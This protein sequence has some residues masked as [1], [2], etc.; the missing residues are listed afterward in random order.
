MTEDSF[1]RVH[2][3]RYSYI[4]FFGERE[5]L[6]IVGG[7]LFRD[8]WKLSVNT[9]SWL[10]IGSGYKQGEHNRSDRSGFRRRRKIQRGR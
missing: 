6:V 8:S 9:R 7:L 4:T 3:I 2:D 5:G 10:L 1:D